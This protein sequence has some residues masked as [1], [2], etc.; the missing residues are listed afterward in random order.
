MSPTNLLSWI[1]LTF[2][3]CLS[4]N[5][6]SNSEKHG[7]HHPS[8]ISLIVQ[9]QHT[10]IEVSEFVG[11]YLSS[12]WICQQEYSAYMPFLFPLVLHISLIYRVLRSTHFPSTSFGRIVSC[13][14]NTVKHFWS[15][16]HAIHGSPMS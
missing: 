16:L 11:L 5:P 7:L 2:S 15:H 3:P 14:Y 10:C 1:I 6:H 8:F 13:I 12:K 9:L 4:I